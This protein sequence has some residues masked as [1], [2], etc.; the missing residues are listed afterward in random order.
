MSPSI[1]ILMGPPGSGKGTQA[2]KLAAKFGFLH[3]STGD[4]LR[5]LLD[6]PEADPVELGAAAKIKT[7]ELAPDWLIY[8]LVFRRISQALAQGQGV[9]LDGAIRN[10]EQAREFAKFFEDQGWWPRVKVIWL[11]LSPEESL[12]RLKR[13]LV[14]PNCGQIFGGEAVPPTRCSRCQTPLVQRG[15]DT[16]VLWQKR[17]ARQGSEAQQP[18]LDFFRQRGLVSAIDSRVT[19]EE[20]YEELVKIISSAADTRKSP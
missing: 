18:A 10:L 7:G 8:R 20:V 4:L 17:W 15:D 9:I 2:K 19:P 5:Q 13:R 11:A 3:L 12:A 14:C 16:E 1:I 6:N